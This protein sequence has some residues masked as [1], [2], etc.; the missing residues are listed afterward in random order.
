MAV[1]ESRLAELIVQGP[2]GEEFRQPLVEGRTVRIG[3]APTDGWAIGWDRTISREHADLCWKDGVLTVA[4]LAN[5]GNAIKLKGAM[6]REISVGGSQKFGKR[7]ADHIGPM[8]HSGRQ[9]L[10]SRLVRLAGSVVGR[11][12][13]TSRR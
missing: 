2:A 1:A 4:C 7:P 9:R 6:H 8:R 5:A 10:G 12:R 13:S 3:R 11:R